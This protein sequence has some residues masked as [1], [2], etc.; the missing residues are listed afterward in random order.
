L[1]IHPIGVPHCP[2]PRLEGTIPLPDGRRLGYAEYGVPA[3]PL[4]LWFHGS[5]GARRQI[6]LVGRRAATSL[7]L[8]LVCVERPGIGASSDHAYARVLDWADDVAVVADVLGHERFMVIGLSGGGPYALAVAHAMPERV[9]SLALLGPVVP[10]FDEDGMV[11]HEVAGPVAL[12][13]RWGG[14]LRAV[15]HPLGFALSRFVR[16]LSPAGLPALSAFAHLLPEG[17]KRVLHDPE[18]QMMFLEDLV[19]GS[20][21]QCRAI[22]HDLALFGRPWGFALS[23][24]PVPVHW[25]HG[26]ADPFVPLAEA[27]AAAAALP[28]VEFVIRPGESHLGE[29]AA[30][31]TVLDE[32]AR[33]WQQATGSP[34]SLSADGGRQPGAGHPRSGRAT[35]VS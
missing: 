1:P 13:R 16:A 28:D 17:D 29:F 15:R 3:G 31:D 4:V 2:P 26:D 8:R 30:A 34:G 21:H 22:L 9:V 24:V 11:V 33:D 25:W 14:F 5:P 20:T 12:T 35:T 19:L 7:G 18:S 10:A 6:P 27:R 32:L 23:D